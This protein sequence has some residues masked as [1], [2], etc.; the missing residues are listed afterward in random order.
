MSQAQ[1]EKLIVS[2]RAKI[3]ETLQSLLET[4]VLKDPATP[5]EKLLATAIRQ[6]ITA[7]TR[8]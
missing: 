6:K 5:D 3:A 7:M 2:Q 1:T 8:T 4:P